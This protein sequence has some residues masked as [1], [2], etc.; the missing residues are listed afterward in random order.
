MISSGKMLSKRPSVPTTTASPRFSCRSIDTASL[1]VHIALAPQPASWKGKLN[2]SCCSFDLNSGLSPRIN[3]NPE[4]PRLAD[5][6]FPVSWL[7]VTIQ[8]VL[9]PGQPNPNRDNFR[10]KRKKK[11]KERTDL[12]RLFSQW[13]SCYAPWLKSPLGS[14]FRS[15]PPLQHCSSVSTRTQKDQHQ[16]HPIH[17]HHQQHLKEERKRKRKMERKDTSEV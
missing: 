3:R 2:S 13:G 10:L 6:N 9:L 1:A 11:R 7:I 17:Q 5:W 8:A 4:S 12:A 16:L 14:R 15:W